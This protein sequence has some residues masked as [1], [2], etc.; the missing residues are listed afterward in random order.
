[1]DIMLAKVEG[2]GEIKVVKEASLDDGSCIVESE[3]GTIDGSLK[4]R[5]EQ[6]EKEI[7]RMI[8]R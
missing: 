4:T 7:E 5:M 8:N 6:I 2:F 1:M 3:Y